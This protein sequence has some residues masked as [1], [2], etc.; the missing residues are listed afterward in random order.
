MAS[1]MALALVSLA[2]GGHARA[3]APAFPHAVHRDS[4][5]GDCHTFAGARAKLAIDAQSCGRDGCHQDAPMTS[6]YAAL[7]RRLVVEYPHNYPAHRLPCGECHLPTLDVA[8]PGVPAIRAKRCFVCHEEKVTAPEV[9]PC[10]PCHGD[11]QPKKKP[12]WHDGEWP[13]QHGPR[14]HAGGYDRH[15][16]QCAQCH[17]PAFCKSCHQIRKP[18]FHRR[19]LK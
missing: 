8:G 6:G 13:T 15:A 18:M 1:A 11:G 9:A 7:R 12:T 2:G 16:R 14:I 4:A 3:D 17:E 10:A 5:C 19:H